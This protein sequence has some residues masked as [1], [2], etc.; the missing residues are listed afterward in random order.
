MYSLR[1]FLLYK[2][3]GGK[4]WQTCL[5][6]APAERNACRPA[7]IIGND[8]VRQSPRNCAFGALIRKERL[9]NICILLRF[10]CRTVKTDHMY[11]GHTNDPPRDLVRDRRAGS[12]T[13][14]RQARSPSVSTYRSNG[15]KVGRI[16]GLI[17]KTLD[18]N[19][20]FCTLISRFPVPWS[21]KGDAMRLFFFYLIGICTNLS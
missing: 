4:I 14:A 16:C 6:P 11:I 17:R 10:F 1:T 2:G 21:K 8:V 5:F 12:P 13:Q 18:K 19:P 7:R 20:N 3:R 9:I 15:E